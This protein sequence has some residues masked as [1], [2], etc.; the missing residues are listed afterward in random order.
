MVASPWGMLSKIQVPRLD[1]CRKRSHHRGDLHSLARNPA[2]SLQTKGGVYRAAVHSI[3]LYSCEMRSVFVADKRM[4][5]VFAN[6]IIRR[7]LCVRRREC[8][9]NRASILRVYQRSSSKEAPTG[10]APLQDIL[11]TRLSDYS[12]CPQRHDHD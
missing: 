11:M 3:L 1:V 10:L 4:R 7:I 9:P 5:T 6:A 12:F 2:P 8:Q